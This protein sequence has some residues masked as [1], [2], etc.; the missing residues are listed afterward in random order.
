[1]AQHNMKF[2]SEEAKAAASRNGKQPL[3]DDSDGWTSSAAPN[4]SPSSSNVAYHSLRQKSRKI[5]PCWGCPYCLQWR[6]ICVGYRLCSV[7]SYGIL[8]KGAVSVARFEL[9]VWNREGQKVPAQALNKKGLGNYAC[10]THMAD[11]LDDQVYHGKRI[12]YLCAEN[13]GG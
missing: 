9:F 10:R 7:A 3:L 8:R 5:I 4:H 6:R 12:R 2:S 11:K 1:M 13:Q